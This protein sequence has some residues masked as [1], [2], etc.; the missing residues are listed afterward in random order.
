MDD[1]DYGERMPEPARCF[2]LV[3]FAQQVMDLKRERDA[4]VH[5]ALRG[6]EFERKYNELLGDTLDHNQRMIGGVL[7]LGLKLAAKE[8]A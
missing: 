2:E 7:A 4:L 8:P 3:Q 5:L 6:L 1:F